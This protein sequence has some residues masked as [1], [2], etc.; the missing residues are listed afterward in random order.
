M[1]L[2]NPKPG[3]VPQRTAR[4][5]ENRNPR[6]V[7]CW[8]Y[9]LT[10]VG[11]GC[12][13]V[14]VQA[15]ELPIDPLDLEYGTP[16][17]IE[18][19]EDLGEERAQWQWDESIVPSRPLDALEVSLEE[20]A[21][22]PGMDEFRASNLWHFLQRN[23]PPAHRN[24]LQAV[25]GLD[26]LRIEMLLRHYRLQ[27]RLAVKTRR[28]WDWALRNTWT[29]QSTQAREIRSTGQGGLPLG[30][31]LRV[32]TR[33][34]SQWNAG[35]FLESDAGERL[36]YGPNPRSPF[37]VDHWS[38]YLVWKVPR[39]NNLWRP[40]RV[41]LGHFQMETGQGLGMWTLP[42]FSSITGSLMRHARGMRPYAGSDEDHGLLGLGLEWRT[43]LWKYEAYA[44]SRSR[45]ARLENGQPVALRSGGLHR[46]ESER[47]GKDRWQSDR[48]GG[49]ATYSGERL[50]WSIGVHQQRI[51]PVGSGGNGTVPTQTIPLGTTSWLIPLGSAR[52]YGEAALTLPAARDRWA[53]T[54]GIDWTLPADVRTGFKVERLADEYVVLS[55]QLL[56]DLKPEPQWNVQWN[57]DFGLGRSLQ[58]SIGLVHR[59]LDETPSSIPL[60]SSQCRGSLDW[61]PAR[62][63][64]VQFRVQSRLEAQSTQLEDSAFRT[65]E[66]ALRTTYSLQWQWNPIPTQ[67]WTLRHIRTRS[68]NAVS[69]IDAPT[70][71]GFGWALSTQFESKRGLPDRQDEKRWRCT[72]QAFWV[73][74]PVWDNRIYLYEAGPPGNFG[75]PAFSGQ[76]WEL[77]AL[78]KWSLKPGQRLWVRLGRKE[79]YETE[80]R[81][82]ENPYTIQIQWDA[83]W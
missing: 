46:S 73:Y 59:R 12:C 39:S 83:R 40:S 11:M 71:Q 24:E 52:I 70:Q 60:V 81:D 41:L 42:G 6:G 22:L 67:S 19:A 27:P 55:A 4:L 14:R 80:I 2:D 26:S 48:W 75:V 50:K 64:R 36:G 58:A 49:V 29:F 69:G 15:Q 78:F 61:T 51:R 54:G 68:H 47:L 18:T 43:Q 37:P 1:A 66:E 79:R 74:A 76:C 25:P 34:G 23:G 77:N 21:A 13:L 8:V 5:A 53:W 72:L 44:S 82:R 10:L 45:D 28:Q 56:Q 3:N 57:T 32:E 16:Q 38:G 30:S 17:G 7:L 33:Y 9:R 63:H 20:L 35:L 62:F 65:L 31:R